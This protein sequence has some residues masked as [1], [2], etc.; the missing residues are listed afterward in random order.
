[1]GEC[2]AFSGGLFL[3]ASRSVID[4]CCESEWGSEIRKKFAI[5][6]YQD[7]KKHSLHEFQLSKN[8]WRTGCRSC[9]ISEQEHGDSE[10]FSFGHVDT[11][12]DDFY[13][14]DVMIHMGN[15]C[16]LKCV[17]CAS[18]NS[19]NW[20]SFV[21]NNPHLVQYP[22]YFEL[23]NERPLS[24]ENLNNFVDENILNKHLKVLRLTGGEPLY[25]KL[26]TR[27]IEKMLE[28]GYY[29]NI[30]LVALTTNGTVTFNDMWQEF[31]TKMTGKLAL[32]FS[33]D[34]R[35]DVFEYIRR[36]HNWDNFCGVVEDMRSIV[37]RL[38]VDA[39]LGVT[40]CLQALN[41][42][43]YEADKEFFE[44]WQPLTR[45]N[46]FATTSIGHPDHLTLHSVPEKLQEQWIK[47]NKW[48]YSSL[49]HQQL[50]QYLDLLD[51]ADK[52]S[53]FRNFI[54]ELGEVYHGD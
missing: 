5:D 26:S 53:S 47:A 9:R 14:Q 24:E 45:G 21:L 31:L 34:G 49:Y 2:N 52:H 36:N 4:V 33:A 37:D 44:N 42:K 40:Y 19:S 16:N 12:V 48:K 39:K 54:P 46:G 27:M 6:Q 38:N 17:Q 20:N 30:E 11:T 50:I 23:Y 35:G 3:D 18:D 41:S 15:T 32:S 43:S 22:E 13:P 28:T 51:V 10:R 1:M 8:G 7:F 29:K 25:N